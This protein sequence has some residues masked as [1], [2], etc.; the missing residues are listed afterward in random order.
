MDSTEREQTYSE[1]NS[2]EVEQW[3][4]VG[5][6][7]LRDI[8]SQPLRESGKEIEGDD[9]E[10]SIGLFVL[11]RVGLEL[12][13]L[14]ESRMDDGQTSLIDG[15]SVLGKGSRSGDRY[16]R[17]TL[18]VSL[19]AMERLQKLTSSRGTRSRS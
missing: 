15:L 8:V 10:R 2:H 11:F 18:A 19:L 9:N 4:L 14:S 1:T 7:E 16:R 17:Q 13:V 12:L 6:D 3:W 5:R